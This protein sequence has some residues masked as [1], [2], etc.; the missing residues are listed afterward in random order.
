MMQ[1]LFVLS[2]E[3]VQWV[4]ERKTYNIIYMFAELS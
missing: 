2:Q 1:K 3:Q 4:F